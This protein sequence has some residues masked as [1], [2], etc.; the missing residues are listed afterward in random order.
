MNRLIMLAFLLLSFTACQGGS[1]NEK[2]Q[3]DDIT[4]A[5]RLAREVKDTAPLQEPPKPEQMSVSTDEIPEPISKPKKVVEPVKEE[6]VSTSKPETTQKERTGP[7]KEVPKQPEKEQE[8]TTISHDSWDKLL[9]KHVNNR[10]NVNYAG[11]KADMAQLQSYLDKL[12]ANAPQKSWTR[13]EKL[14]YWINAYNAYTVKL[15]VDNYPLSSITDL[16]GGKPWDVKWIKL[17]NQTYSLNNIENDI[18]R[19]R[20]KDARIH[21]AVNCAA[22]SC[23]PLHNRAFTAEKLNSQL[24][25]LSRSFINNSAYNTINSN[26][27]EISKIFDWY[28]E[29][30]GSSLAG[31]LNKY[32]NTSINE[33]ATVNFKEYDWSLNNQ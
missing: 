14:A 11:F 2:V 5:D 28:R 22:A 33:N 12:S 31:Y 25:Q 30:F 9:Q 15:I 4:P 26:K 21:F 17:G 18:I 27:V 8:Q 6:P 1:N 16:H 10:G 19:P 13:D 32:S 3:Q 24:D 20:F 29:D 23:P 7:T